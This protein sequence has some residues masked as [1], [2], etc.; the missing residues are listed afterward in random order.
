[1]PVTSIRLQS[2]NPTIL[3]PV[4]PEFIELKIPVLAVLPVATTAHCIDIVSDT[5]QLFDMS[6]YA[7]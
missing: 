5:E 6:Q 2:D 1:M 7:L 3:I 4:E